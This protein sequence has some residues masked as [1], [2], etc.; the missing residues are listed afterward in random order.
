MNLHLHLMQIYVQSVG[1]CVSR[2]DP[3]APVRHSH[4]HRARR[5]NDFGIKICPLKSPLGGAGLGALGVLRDRTGWA[6]C[7]P[8]FCEA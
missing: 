2:G 7:S 5:G 1:V 4:I 8:G 3:S 6:W